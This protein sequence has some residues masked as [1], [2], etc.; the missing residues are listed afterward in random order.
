MD[1]FVS[2]R[3]PLDAGDFGIMTR[4][5]V[6]HLN[7]MPERHRFL[8]GLRAWVGFRQTGLLIDRSARY[9]GR[10]KFT[11]SKLLTLALDGLIGFS[12]S[13]L[14]GCGVIGLIGL[15][16]VLGAVV[17]GIVRGLIGAGWLPGWCWVGMLVAIS[18]GAQLLLAAV[19]GEYV[20]RILHE[21]YGRPLYLVR[22]RIGIGP[23]RRQA[24]RV[25][26]RTRSR[27]R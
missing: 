4:R 11:L 16:V 27:S 20:G 12:E 8:R 23:P 24:R 9:T 5:V 14:R 17:A 21:V 18:A 3:L 2:I 1:R 19:F 6:D 10:P 26:S 22:R 13:P 15:V 25:Q 7:S